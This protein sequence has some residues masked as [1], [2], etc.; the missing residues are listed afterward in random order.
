MFDG[1]WDTALFVTTS[2]VSAEA[3]VT[4]DP[5]R[6]LQKLADRHDGFRGMNSGSVT[7]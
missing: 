6:Q 2:R 3:H 7:K 5:S 4:D 1:E